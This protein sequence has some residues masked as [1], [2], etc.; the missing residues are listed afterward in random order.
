MSSTKPFPF[1]SPF[2]QPISDE[3]LKRI[4]EAL[5]AAARGEL[6][7]EAIDLRGP[8]GITNATPLAITIKKG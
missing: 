6:T 4:E 5:L 8:H 1:R 2:T 3:D 7:E